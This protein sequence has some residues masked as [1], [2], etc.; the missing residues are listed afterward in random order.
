MA[1]GT[2]QN[3]YDLVIIGGGINGAGIARDAVMRGLSVALFEKNDFSTGATWASSGMI[4]GG[5]R[6]LEQD[7]TV[8]KKS[9]YDSGLIQKIAPHLLFRVPFLFPVGPNNFSNRVMLE[10]AEVYFDTYDRYAPLKGGAPHSRLTKQ[11]ALAVEPGL[12]EHIIGAVTTDEWGIDSPRLTF[13]NVQDA[14]ERGADVH[15]YHEVVGFLRDDGSSDKRGAV[16]GV[17][18]RDRVNGGEREVYGRITFNATGAW[19]EKTANKVGA[20]MCRVRPGKGI[21]LLLAGRV[22]NYAIIA[23][24]IDGRQIFIAPH[25]NV[26]YIGTTD[27]DYWGDLDDIPVL[28]DEVKYLLDGIRPVFPSVDKYRII[29]TTVGCRPTLYDDNKYESQLSRDHAVYDHEVEGVPNFMSIAGGKLAAYRLMSE[30]AVDEI[31]QKLGI[32]AECRTHLEALPGGEAHDLTT[33]AFEEVGLGKYAAGRILYRHGSRSDQ[34][35]AMM[36]KNPEWTTIV[37]PSEPVT[38]AELRYV[39][40]DEMVA[41]LD[42]CKRRSRLGQGLDGGWSATLHAAEI[43]CDE[44]GL[45]QRDRFDVALSFQRARWKDREGIERDEQLA[46]EM[47]GQTWFF[48][49]GGAL[50][51]DA[52]ALFNEPAAQTSAVATQVEKASSRESA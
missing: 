2:P 24:A 9:C 45:S 30:H 11:E 17:R 28:E 12:P 32:E 6:Y 15:N 8:T 35:L 44:K 18:V 31:C 25:Q 49:A 3:P 10:L 42:D 22:T 46:A 5:V 38:E 50:G 20:E 36:R 33:D 39:M 29:D 37:D 51:A 52:T 1:L 19:A 13:I 47:V 40:R 26:T 43:F 21:H 48:E 16:R 41:T 7:P 23:D 34:I 14:K 27:D 4:H